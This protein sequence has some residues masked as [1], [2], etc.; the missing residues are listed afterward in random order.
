MCIATS[1]CAKSASKNDGTN[2]GFHAHAKTRHNGHL[3]SPKYSTDLFGHKVRLLQGERGTV[4]GQQIDRTDIGGK[5]I[6]KL[7]ESVKEAPEVTQKQVRMKN[8]DFEKIKIFQN[9]D[10]FF[11]TKTSIKRKG[12]DFERPFSTTFEQ[13]HRRESAV[14]VR[15]PKGHDF[16]RIAAES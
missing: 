8:F 7:F 4:W 9:F 6:A 12:S 14:M 16:T 1:V 13:L 3:H 5:D 10:F 2:L 15:I 11:L